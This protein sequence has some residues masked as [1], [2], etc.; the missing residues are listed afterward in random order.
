MKRETLVKTLEKRTLL[1]IGVG[2]RGEGICHHYCNKRK[3]NFEECRP[4]YKSY[5]TGASTCFYS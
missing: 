5:F 2:Y 1:G 4:L 3:F